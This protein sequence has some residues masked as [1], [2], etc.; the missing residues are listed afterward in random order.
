MPA[1]RS[2]LAQNRS[3]Q[4]RG[5]K[6]GAGH[7]MRF[8]IRHPGRTVS[9]LSLG[10]FLPALPMKGEAQPKI[11]GRLAAIEPH[12]ACVPARSPA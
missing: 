11:P 1:D 12:P 7:G 8:D 2:V 10:A 4:A 5:A 6:L 9:N 3:P